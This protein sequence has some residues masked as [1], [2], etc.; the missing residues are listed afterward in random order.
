MQMY[1]THTGKII[2]IL[3]MNICLT[4]IFHNS[5]LDFHF[6]SVRERER[7]LIMCTFYCL[8]TKISEY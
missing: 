8:T 5:K 2:Q 3:K 4:R 1:I 6:K 7:L